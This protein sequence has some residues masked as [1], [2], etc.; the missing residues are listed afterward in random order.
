MSLHPMS[1]L[2]VTKHRWCQKQNVFI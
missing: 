1:K 2:H